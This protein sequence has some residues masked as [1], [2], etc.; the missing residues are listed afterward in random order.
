[1]KKGDKSQQFRPPTWGDQYVL[2]C[3]N[4][5]IKPTVLARCAATGI[6]TS[7]FYRALK[8]PGVAAWL[9]QQI[10]RVS[11]MEAAD[12]RW[13]IRRAAADGNMQAVELWLEHFERR[14]SVPRRPKPPRDPKDPRAGG[15]ILDRL[16]SLLTQQST[17]QD[18]IDRLLAELTAEEDSNGITDS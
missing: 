14:V 4:I 15:D 1:M 2:S 13:A 6:D 3:V 16:D 17:T 12:V 5:D 10:V 7:T 11:A 18:Q 8:R 9:E